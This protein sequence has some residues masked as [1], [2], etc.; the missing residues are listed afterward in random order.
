MIQNKLNI[1]DL[2]DNLD[3]NNKNNA[4]ILEEEAKPKNVQK[5]LL[6]IKQ[7]NGNNTIQLKNVSS[8][9]IDSE[10][11]KNVK[12]NNQ[13]QNKNLMK[14]NEIERRNK[15]SNK[16][17]DNKNDKENGS[18]TKQK[19][20]KDKKFEI[21]ENANIQ[22]KYDEADFTSEA[23]KEKLKALKENLFLSNLEE[24]EEKVRKTVKIQKTD[25]IEKI[26][27]LKNTNKVADL[28]SSDNKANDNKFNS[29]K[30]SKRKDS[31]EFVLTGIENE[32]EDENYNSNKNK[33]ISK[34]L[35]SS[36]V[37]CS[38]FFPLK[39]FLNLKFKIFILQ[40]KCYFMRG[41]LIITARKGGLQLLMVFK[42]LYFLLF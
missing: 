40:M 7:T 11:N 29:Q 13:T 17:I 10:A 42:V 12:V 9:K 16:P 36:L 1:I 21:D 31:G 3:N 39:V 22:L 24:K 15:N 38:T 14:E 19:F 18:H 6:D 5:N 2:N 37:N 8:S 35:F 28:V 33:N 30:K 27:N 25:N 26:N 32:K 4:F 23:G 34:Y 20:K 41:S